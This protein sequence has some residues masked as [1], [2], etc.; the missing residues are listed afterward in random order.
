MLD[1][2]GSVGRNN[3][4]IAIMFIRNVV[5]FFS[6]GLDASRFGFI[7]YS[8]NEHL[9]FDLDDHTTLSSLDSAISR[10]N[11]R[12]GWTATALALNGSALLLNP[13]N[14]FGARLN[15]EG[16]PKIAILITGMYFV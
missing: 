15:S 1:Q 11:Y 9:E 2:S 4:D 14:G 12:G 5:S 8:T 6:V 7:A 13:Q 16:I 3:H 10:V